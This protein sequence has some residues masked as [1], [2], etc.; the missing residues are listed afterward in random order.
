MI[1]FLYQNLFSPLV[2]IEQYQ[3]KFFTIEQTN[4]IHYLNAD[5]DDNFYSSELGLKKLFYEDSTFQVSKYGTA[6]LVAAENSYTVFQEF[7]KML[8]E[9]RLDIFLLGEFDDCQVLELFKRF[10]FKGRYKELMFDYQQ[11]VSNVI[12]QQSESKEANQ[13]ILQLGYHFPTHFQ[14]DDYFTLLVF[15]GLFGGFSHSLL[16]TELRE[17]EGLAYTI[18]SQFNVYTGLLNVYAGIDKKNQT[19]TLKLINKQFSDIK[20][21]RFS[22]SLLTQTKKMLKANLKLSCDLPRTVIE[23]HYLHWYFIKKYSVNEI[24]D[25][26]DRVSKADVL[27]FTKKVKLQTLYF[28]EGNK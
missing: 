25:K 27:N 8:R 7:Q 14:D 1:D 3:P 10:P 28:L 2:T 13:S 11:E 26:V 21:G 18:G 15:N 6:D 17:K 22:E 12:R 16:F 20:M 4:L 9:D 5:K 23:R 19:K 24:V